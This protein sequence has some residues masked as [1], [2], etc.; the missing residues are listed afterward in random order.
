M[1]SEAMTED[2]AVEGGFESQGSGAQS[3]CCP[4]YSSASAAVGKSAW[5][6]RVGT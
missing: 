2:Y 5:L 6:H 3:Y 4:P 1:G